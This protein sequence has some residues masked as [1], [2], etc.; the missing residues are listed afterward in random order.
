[1]AKKKKVLPKAAKP[2]KR[3]PAAKK[4]AAKKSVGAV[5]A[6][7]GLLLANMIPQSLSGETNQ[8]SEPMIAVN[9]GDPLKIVGTAFTPDPMGGN[10]APVFLS[11]DGGN[12]WSLNAIV[13]G[14]DMTG[15]I[16]IAFSGASSTLYAG[17]LRRDSPSPGDTRMAILRTVDSSNPATMTVLEDR[18]QPDQ[19]FAQAGRVV[20][21][22]DNGKERVFVGNN[23]FDAGTKTATLDV[24]LNAGAATPA[25]QKVRL[26]PR[27]TVGQDGPQVRPTVHPDGTIYAAY[28]G[29][30]SQSGSWPGNTL[31]VTSDVVV[32][33]DDNWGDVAAPFTSLIDA[34][35]GLVG[36]RVA[37]NVSFP[38]DRNG[39]T[40]NGQQR[41]GGSLSIAVDPRPG[42]S[43][44]VYLAWGDEQV[45][46]QFTL[47]VR[48]ST[49]RGVTWSAAD[50]LTVPRAT[51]AAVAIN[52]NGM[53]GLLCQQLTGQGSNLRWETHFRRSTDGTSWTDLILANTLALTPVKTFDPYLGDY[54]H[55]VSVGRDFYGIFSASNTPD[56]ANFP[57]GVNYQRNANFTTQKLL[58]LNG[59]TVVQPSIDPFFFKFTP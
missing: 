48:R 45:V 14:G 10:L 22:S 42:Q 33:R 37:R 44:T 26:E 58:A 15:D 53:I 38:F 46:T 51:N 8:D 59:T 35:D 32:V 3:K 16:T 23:D 30:R 34:A 25:I 7:A 4:A 19:P 50:L 11:S 24:A 28:Y 49:D 52:S 55:L 39:K 31:K 5:A 12:T 29:W 1:M 18:L 20:G 2:A 54:D 40:A 6:A 17:I 9:P 41:L 47:H 43:S 13:P 27:A 56:I 57:N 36:V 21:G